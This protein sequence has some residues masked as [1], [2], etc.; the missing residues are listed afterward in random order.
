MKYL[1]SILMDLGL[2]E[3]ESKVFS[4]LTNL[5]R[6]KLGTLVKATN[7]HRGTTYNILQ[8]LIGKGLVYTSNFEGVNYYSISPN[9]FL[10][11]L[12]EKEKNLMEEKEFIKS[13]QKNIKFNRGL[14]K[15]NEEEEIQI[16]TGKIAFKNFYLDLMAKSKELSENYFFTG[17]GGE[18]RD[19]MGETYYKYSQNLKENMK[20]KCKVILNE[21]K[22]S[23]PFAREVKGK[24]RWLP[25][26]LDF[27]VNTWVYSNKVVI[28][29]WYKKPL[30]TIVLNDKSIAKN[31]NTYF[32]SLW[33]N[34]T[35]KVNERFKDI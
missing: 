11:I 17:N 13:L 16:Y 27:P 5:G 6:S 28:V 14:F 26:E 31:Y 8:R 22:K 15:N 35:L 25:Q 7:L 18:M 12:H 10:D 1:S 4:E 24:I 21:K 30:H 29:D 32:K 3:T 23:H 9:A 19:I 34:T 33:R 2:T 20:V